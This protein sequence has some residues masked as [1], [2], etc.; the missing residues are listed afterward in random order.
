MPTKF[1]TKLRYAFTGT[2]NPNGITPAVHVFRANSLYDPD[3]TGVGAQPR[4]FDQIIAFYDHYVVIHSKITVKFVNRDSSGPATVGTN[5]NF[6]VGVDLNDSSDTLNTINDYME[7]G[8]A[9]YSMLAGTSGTRDV[10]S[11]TK[12]FTNKFLGRSKPLSD[13]QLKGSSTSNPVEQG[14][15]HIFANAVGNFDT[16]PMD[17]YVVI[18]YTAVFIEPKDLP[19]S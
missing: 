13:S 1:T 17:I 9:K 16:G 12:S 3:Q 2:L 8:Y 6:I 4:G 10:V 7:H 11:S 19:Q 15:Y 14:Y 5:A 18:D